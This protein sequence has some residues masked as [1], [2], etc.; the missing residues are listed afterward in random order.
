MAILHP[1]LFPGTRPKETACQPASR[2][3]DLNRESIWISYCALGRPGRE[4]YHLCHFTLHNRLACPVEP[5]GKLEI[6]GG[7]P[8]ILTRHGWMVIYH[9]VCELPKSRVAAHYYAIPPG[10]LI[11]S[12]KSSA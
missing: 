2:V 6:G 7:T 3:V 12:D 4:P 10:V 11:L 1:P 5:W 8:P 9:G